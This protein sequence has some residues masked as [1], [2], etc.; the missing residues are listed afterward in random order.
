MKKWWVISGFLLALSTWLYFTGRLELLVLSLA[1]IFG[2]GARAASE[3]YNRAQR[4]TDDLLREIEETMGDTDK[5]RQGHDEE[6]RKIEQEDFSGVPLGE[7]LD[8]A[9]ERERRRTDRTEP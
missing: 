4:K 6:V 9:N 5:M 7:L 2:A 3:K 1:G 8:G